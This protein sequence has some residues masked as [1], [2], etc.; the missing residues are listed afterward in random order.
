MA[1]RRYLC[2]RPWRRPGPEPSSRLAAAAAAPASPPLPGLT[3]TRPQC[4]RPTP[5]RCSLPRRRRPQLPRPR[6]PGPP[7]RGWCSKSCRCAR[8][9]HFKCVFPQ[10]ASRSAPVLLVVVLSERLPWRVSFGS[11][12]TPDRRRPLRRTPSARRRRP[13][14]RRTVR[15]FQ[16]E[17]LLPFGPRSRHRRRSRY[18]WRPTRSRNR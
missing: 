4:P 2:S 8:I 7:T 18:R 17:G 1:L 16:E 9:F 11:R 14:E 6:P 3:T 13:P 5:R 15:S 12:P 10:P